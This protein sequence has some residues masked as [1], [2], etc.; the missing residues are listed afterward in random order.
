LKIVSKHIV[1]CR[2]RITWTRCWVTNYWNINS[3]KS[4]GSSYITSSPYLSV[5]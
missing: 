1:H 3:S 4:L 5:R 2:I